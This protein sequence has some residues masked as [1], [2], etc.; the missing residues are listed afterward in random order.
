MHWM[1]YEQYHAHNTF[2]MMLLQYGFLGFFFFVL[3]IFMSLKRLSKTVGSCKHVQK[4]LLILFFTYNVARLTEVYGTTNYLIVL[5]FLYYSRDF[6]RK[7]ACR[8]ALPL[9]KDRRHRRR[10][11]H[12][13]AHWQVASDEWEVVSE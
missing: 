4:F 9:D 10:R 2:L 6:A 3:L 12:R 1:I 8:N 5:L 13:G 11:R 7:F